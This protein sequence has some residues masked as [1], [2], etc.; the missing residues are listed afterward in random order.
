[1]RRRE[2]MRRLVALPAAAAAVFLAKMGEGGVR[3]AF[4]VSMG[5]AGEF[6]ACGDVISFGN[7][8]RLWRVT[9]LV[10]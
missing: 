4:G 2:W 7:D 6:L 9:G 3:G 5:R 8:G 1:M 10:K